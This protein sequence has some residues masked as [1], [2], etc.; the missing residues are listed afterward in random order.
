MEYNESA[1]PVVPL[2]IISNKL[3]LRYWKK[4][5]YRRVYYIELCNTDTFF[6]NLLLI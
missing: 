4:E 1:I 6:L 5:I 3:T 2:S